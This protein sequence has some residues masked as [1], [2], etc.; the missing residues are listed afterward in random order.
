MERQFGEKIRH[1]LN[2]RG[3][4]Q[5]EL[6]EKSGISLGT[7]KALVNNRAKNTTVETLEKIA[8]V[9]GIELEYFFDSKR[10][11]IFELLGDEV[12]ED[13]KEFILNQENI[14]FLE[15][16]KDL[17]ETDLDPEVIRTI[18]NNYREIMKLQNK[19]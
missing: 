10:V 13:I 11:T 14:G 7:V 6:A 2:L 17:A 9:L 18:I 16:A 3:L 4:T 12:P 1:L 8:Q 15:L 5:T 19:T